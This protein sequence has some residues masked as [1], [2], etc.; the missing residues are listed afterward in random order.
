MKAQ[1][2]IADIPLYDAS[3]TIRG[4][5]RV[6]PERGSFHWSH[7]EGSEGLEGTFTQAVDA[8]EAVGFDKEQTP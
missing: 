7:P 1:M 3:G 6:W 5:G 4:H 2:L 8:L